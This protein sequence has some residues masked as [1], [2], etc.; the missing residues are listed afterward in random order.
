MT[1][2]KDLLLQPITS[3]IKKKPTPEEI[4]AVRKEVRLKQDGKSIKIRQ[5]DA[6]MLVSPGGRRTWQ[7]YEAPL[8]DPNHR[9][10]PLGIWELFLLLTDRHPIWKLTKRRPDKP[11]DES[12]SPNK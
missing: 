7:N 1:Q 8:D 12:K 4:R 3:R 6:A 11:A 2:L 9:D 10:I 5:E